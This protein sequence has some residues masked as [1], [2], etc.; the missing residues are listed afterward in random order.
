MAKV[1]AFNI[2]GSKTVLVQPHTISGVAYTYGCRWFAG[3]DILLG[4]SYNDAC[5]VSFAYYI[6]L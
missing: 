4:I 1:A 2:A 6:Y 3:V 5:L